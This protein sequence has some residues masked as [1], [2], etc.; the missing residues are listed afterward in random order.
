MS[1]EEDQITPLNS[2][3]P[4]FFA[5]QPSRSD[6]YYDEWMAFLNWPLV[7]PFISLSLLISFVIGVCI[8]ANDYLTRN[9]ARKKR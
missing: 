4:T 8:R 1:D 9:N 6:P 7:L 5:L 2:C 3:V